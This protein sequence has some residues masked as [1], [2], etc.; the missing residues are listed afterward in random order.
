VMEITTRRPIGYDCPACATRS[1]VLHTW[2]MIGSTKSLSYN[3]GA[4]HSF[5]FSYLVPGNL[6]ATTHSTLAMVSYKLVAEAIPMSPTYEFGTT[7]SGGILSQSRKRA[8]SHK[9]IVLSQSLRLSRSILPSVEPKQSHRIFPPTKLSAMLTLPSV[10]HPGAMD[11]S[12]DVIISGLNIRDTKLRWSLRKLTWR[13]DEHAKVVSPACAIHANKVGGVEGKG[14]LYQDTRV[15]GTGNINN[16]WKIDYSAG[17]AEMVIQVGTLP[18]AMA[19]CHVDAMS[20]VHVS[21]T[22]VM[23]CVVSQEMLRAS[24]EPAKYGGQ[25]QPTGNTRVLRMSFPMLV[26]ERGGMGISWDEE[27]PPRYEDVAW[28]APPTFE[29]IEGAISDSQERDSTDEELETVEGIQRS[30]SGSPSDRNR[31]GSSGL[32]VNRLTRTDSDASNASNATI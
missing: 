14:I 19:A 30:R 27:I 20:G 32:S 18:R 21:H 4:P 10:I 9:P 13:I 28:N 16:G 23:E 5:P 15:V 22:L 3:N 1:K 26:T 12:V 24:V 31:P 29:Q 17:K 8:N 2:V 25:Y 7:I 6:P 11:N